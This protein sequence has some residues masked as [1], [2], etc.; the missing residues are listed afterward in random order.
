VDRSTVVAAKT[1]RP[2]RPSG[3][4]LIGRQAARIREVQAEGRECIGHGVNVGRAEWALGADRGTVAFDDRENDA[5]VAT[6]SHEA[7]DRCRNGVIDAEC[8]AEQ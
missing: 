7:G 4:D 2:G 1:A 6:G 5:Q 8:A 3:P